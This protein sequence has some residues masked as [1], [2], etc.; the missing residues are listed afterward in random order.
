MTRQVK[1]NAAMPLVQQALLSGESPKVIAE[2][3]GISYDALRKEANRANINL[4]DRLLTDPTLARPGIVYKV[5][6]S[7]IDRDENQ[8]RVQ[9]DH[10][11]IK[12]L[13]ESLKA[14][15]QSPIKIKR[16]TRNESRFEIIHG[17]C[18]WRAAQAAG[19]VFLDA[20]FDDGEYTPI[21][22]LLNQ[23]ADNQGKPLT[24]W[25]ITQACVRLSAEGLTH[26]E[27]SNTLT[28]RGVDHIS[29]PVVS[30]LLRI[31]KL[32]SELQNAV[33]KGDWTI[34]HARMALSIKSDD[35]LDALNV[36]IGTGDIATKAQSPASLSLTISEMH[37]DTFKFMAHK[38]VGIQCET[39]EKRIEYDHQYFCPDDDCYE[40]IINAQQDDEPQSETPPPLADTKPG[41]AAEKPEP[42]E[43]LINSAG[44]TVEPEDFDLDKEDETATAAK[45]AA[46]RMIAD[47]VNKSD[48]ATLTGFVA[49]RMQKHNDP[50]DTSP[51]NYWVNAAQTEISRKTIMAGIGIAMLD[52][53]DEPQLEELKVQLGFYQDESKQQLNAIGIGR[54]DPLYQQAVE[55]VKQKPAVSGGCLQRELKIGG[56]RSRVMLERMQEDAIVEPADSAGWHTVKK[57]KNNEK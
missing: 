16:S 28:K 21:E 18:R 19:L 40:A 45:D 22:N 50:S 26:Q 56:W 25:D 20:V 46:M 3:L 52:R 11:Y 2:Q 57:G 41:N 10:D 38:Q 51:L 7:F 48:I 43:P 55:F 17:E 6:I 37:H 36:S 31:P 14:G 24:T 9:F 32:P 29:R 12:D 4:G 13:A 15:Q 30:N 1:W 35:I 34:T 27:I 44:Q 8:A 53:M 39:C 49:W 5:P 33:K 47:A 23:I 54:S 42:E